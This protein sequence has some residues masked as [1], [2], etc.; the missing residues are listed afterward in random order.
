MFDQ[1]VIW[2]L[3]AAAIATGLVAGVFL[4]FSDFVMRSL[5]AAEPA[6]GME[7]MQYINRMVYGSFFL[8]LF[9]AMAPLSAVIAI[10]AFGFMSGALAALLIAGGLLYLLGVFLVTVARNV[11][12]NKRLDR[13][14]IGREGIGAYWPLYV[15]DWTWWNHVRTLASLGAASCYL[16]GAILAGQAA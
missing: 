12:M 5:N 16:V 8:L 9:M 14:N 13:I 10:Y 15:R 3:A 11:P 7:A 6:A 4:T 1:M 2:G